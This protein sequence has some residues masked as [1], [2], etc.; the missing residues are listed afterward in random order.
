M[1]PVYTLM[2]ARSSA[3]ALWDVDTRCSREAPGQQVRGVAFLHTCVRSC[4][5]VNLE[6]R[7]KPF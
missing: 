3:V 4:L 7:S 6:S 2:S 1:K 5:S